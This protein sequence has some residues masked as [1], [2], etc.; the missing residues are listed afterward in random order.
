MTP[1]VAVREF[2]QVE[3]EIIDADFVERSHDSP[4][5]KRPERFYR[6]RVRPTANV[7]VLGVVHHFML[8]AD[9]VQRPIVACLIGRNERNIGRDHLAHEILM[10]VGFAT[11]DDLT[12]DIAFAGD[13]SDH[14]GFPRSALAVRAMVAAMLIFLFATDENLIDL[15]FAH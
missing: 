15:D 12:H 14:F 3:R 7:F 6:L 1:V 5:E 2:R 13:S 4:T 8:E 9:I 11:I 10:C